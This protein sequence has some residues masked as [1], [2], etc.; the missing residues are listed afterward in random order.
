MGCDCQV[1]TKTGDSTSSDDVEEK[2]GTSG[3]RW[4]RVL[5]LK[6]RNLME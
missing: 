3:T 6:L 2:S 5:G 1:M 4:F